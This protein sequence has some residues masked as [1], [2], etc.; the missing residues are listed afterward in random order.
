MSVR[1]RGGWRL[2][3]AEWRAHDELQDTLA[4]TLSMMLTLSSPSFLPPPP[5]LFP[6]Q[7]CSERKYDHAKFEG[8]VLEF[9]FD[10][11]NNPS[12]EDLPFFCADVAAFLSA[13]E[14]NVVCVHCKAGKGRTGLLITVF[15][16]FID[17]W[18]TASEA[19]RYYAFARTQ[20]QKGVTIASQIRW[21][22]YWE[23]YLALSRDG[24]GLPPLVPLALTRMLL[25]KKA[26]P[27]DHFVASCHGASISSKDKDMTVVETRMNDG[28]ER[29][30]LKFLSTGTNKPLVF[31]KGTHTHTHTH[32]CA[33]AHECMRYR[34]HLSRA[35][36]HAG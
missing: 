33:R 32:A 27:Y 10:D 29:T 36:R 9:P 8:R 15:L 16:L 19:L 28:S 13:D 24:I 1:H 17:E 20:N 35:F 22:Y 4:S 23:K 6:H 25:S 2:L 34:W 18:Q 5:S 30:E 21:V 14:K 31:E 11:H 26:P 7:L 12:F 3:R